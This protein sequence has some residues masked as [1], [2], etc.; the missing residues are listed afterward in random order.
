MSDEKLERIREAYAEV[1]SEQPANYQPRQ[2]LKA[3]RGHI[4]TAID[5]IERR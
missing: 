1:E 2:K 3:A 5:A 4:D